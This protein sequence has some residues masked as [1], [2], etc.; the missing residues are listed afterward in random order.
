MSLLHWHQISSSEWQA[1]GLGRCFTVI[2]EGDKIFAI[3]ER[4]GDAGILDHSPRSSLPKAQRRCQE[5][6]DGVVTVKIALSKPIVYDL[7]G[8]RQ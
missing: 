8:V 2:K 7:P 4:V 3:E 5:I 1:G 6:L